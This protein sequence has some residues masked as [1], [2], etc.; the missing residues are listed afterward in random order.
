[1]EVWAVDKALQY[2]PNATGGRM[3][4]HIRTRAPLH[5]FLHMARGPSTQFEYAT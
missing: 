3:N 5:T 1:M 2:A 4:V